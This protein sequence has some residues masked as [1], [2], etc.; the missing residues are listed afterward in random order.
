MSKK[1]FESEAPRY[2]V[3][4]VVRACEILRAFR[5]RDER[6]TLTEVASRTGL[7]NS[8][9]FRLLRTLQHE[10]LLERADGNSYRLRIAPLERPRYRIGFA[11]QTPDSAFA[12]EVAESVRQAAAARNVQLVEVDNRF[13]VEAALR[14]ADHLIRERVDAAIEF[15][16]FAE[17]APAVAAKFRE[18]GTPL[19]AVDI[20]H[21]GAVFFGADNYRAGLIAGR[22]LGAWAKRNGC[23]RPDRIVLLGMSVS[24]PLTES[25]LEG[26]LAGLAERIQIDERR[27]LRVD[28]GGTFEGGLEA[29]RRVLRP[30]DK[31]LISAINDPSVLGLLR[32][33]EEA[34]AVQTCAAV[35]QGASAEGRRELR[36]PGTRLLGSVGY[37]PERYGEQLLELAA[38]LLDGE[39]VPPA[40]FVEH[41]MITP[42]NVDLRY[43]GDVVAAELAA[44]TE[45]Y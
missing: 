22:F 30:G 40:V 23:A 21:P 2:L 3:D 7:T 36:R 43:A 42:A 17:A 32:A 10:G 24:G 41:E 12:R 37:F 1:D 29:G 16:T 15:Q 5:R 44:G 14:G 8:R 45:S 28:G 25:R 27:V 33:A 35:S 9:S 11:G 18:A 19:I 13:S 4:S 20:P 39:P 38:K 34:G 26:T 31:A 6:L